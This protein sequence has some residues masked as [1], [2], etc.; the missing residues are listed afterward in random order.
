M[1]IGTL[2][3]RR[4]YSLGRVF[5][6]TLAIYLF[7]MVVGLVAMYVSPAMNKAP[8]WQKIFSWQNVLNQVISILFFVVF[9]FITLNMFYRLIIGK[10]KP[11][12]FIQPV[13][14]SFLMIG[15]YYA[16]SF[17]CFTNTKFEVSVNEG[18]TLE[19]QLT[20]GVM[21][22]S[23]VIS[24]IFIIGSSLLIA[25][26]TYL[27]DEK[28]QRK[29]LEE[30]KM[31]LEVEKSQA[32][33]NFLKAQINPHFLHN[34]LNFLYAKSLPYSTELSE[35]ILT[36]SDIMRYALSPSATKDGKVMLKEE[37]EHVRNVIKINQLRFSNNL[38]V[39][40]DVN[41]VV[42]GATIIPF[43][44]I[45]LV[46]NAFK[47]GD[48]KSPQYP[49]DIKLDVVGKSQ[50]IFY[51]RNKKRPGAKELSTGIGL[52]NIKKQLD[53]TYGKGYVLNVK[54][55]AEFYTTEL[56]INTTV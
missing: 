56:T 15:G 14:L 1:K 17:F 43:I 4:R 23:Y 53:L 36:L 48:L 35:G 32:N 49:I 39:Q 19:D 42:N 5:W 31:Q 29:I 45:T 8:N 40:F 54:D 38:N 22:F 28:K 3:N 52:D 51:C 24:S 25:Y 18:K 21:I 2:F 20:L 13:V 55:E 7:F 6:V 16:I 9:Y 30:Q 50:M 37:I 47:H 41:G 26:L 46:E 27:R 11:V 10:H 44:L 34:T 12:Q 33:F